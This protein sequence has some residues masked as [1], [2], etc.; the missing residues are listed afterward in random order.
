MAPVVRVAALLFCSVLSA[1]AALVWTP[2]DGWKAEGGILEGVIKSLP[3]ADNALEAMN[4]GKRACDNRSW[5]EAIANYSRVVEEWPESVF[6]P[7]AYFQMSFAYEGRG[8]YM[9]AYRCLETIVKNYPDYDAFDAVI[10]RE[11]HLAKAIQDG[12]TP[13]IWGWLPWFTNYNDSV[14]I[15]E[16]VVTN[17]P[18]SD[19]APSALMNI[20]DVADREGLYDTA[21]DALDR[22]I[23]AYPQSPYTPAAYMKMAAVYHDMVEGSA[24]DQTPTRNAI[25]YYQ[26]YLILFPN[27]ADVVK[28]ESEL[29]SLR[30]TY[31]HSKL[32]FADFYYKYRNNLVASSIY[33]N[34]AITAAPSSESAARAREMLVKVEN[35]VLAP[36]TPYDWFFGRYE[37]PDTESFED[38][39]A[40]EK[41]SETQF[42]IADMDVFPVSGD[43][44]GYKPLAPVFGGG[45]DK[46]LIDDGF[47]GEKSETTEA[48]SE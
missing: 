41:L 27:G 48:I 42:D 34:E 33:Y 35:G 12:A 11:F 21:F 20:A 36:M 45:L 16:S 38:E 44:A 22:L 7:E 19:L 5:R 13:Y 47:Y 15:Y 28:A 14:K 1:R 29:N 8:Q 32:D 17:A 9:D 6:A 3:N 37:K 2:D 39:I 43:S 30:N 23:N 40:F 10:A 18:F 25:S 24:Y 46:Y 26:D 31:A 4:N